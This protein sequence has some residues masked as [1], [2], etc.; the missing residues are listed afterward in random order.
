MLLSLSVSVVK[1]LICFHFFSTG[2]FS[3]SRY[4]MGLIVNL[5]AQVKIT[6]TGENKKIKY[7]LQERKKKK[8]PM[9]FDTLICKCM[10][11]FLKK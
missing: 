5:A 7:V 2:V 6:T 10:Y 1:L 3:W 9:L 4:N 8:A 11:Y